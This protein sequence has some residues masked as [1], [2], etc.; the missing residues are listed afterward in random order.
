MADDLEA[1]LRQAAQR[2][3]QRQKPAQRKGREPTPSR[4]EPAQPPPKQPPRP[5]A[6]PPRSLD[7]SSTPVVEAVVIDE[8]SL[9][10]H[11]L[12]H[13]DTSQ[14]EKRAEHLSEEVE[15]ADEAMGAR[16]AQRFDHRIGTL[17]EDRLGPLESSQEF[18]PLTEGASAVARDIVTM[19]K[20]PN[21]VRQAV[22]LSEILTPAHLRWS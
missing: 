9:P 10:R 13:V 6:R 19:L 12:L 21:T 5:A 7:V 20:S 8:Q 18:D 17:A 14:F 22:V 1:F 4:P 3:A 11:L 16:L 15:L 2:R